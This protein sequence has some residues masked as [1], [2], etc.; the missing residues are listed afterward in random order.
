MLQCVHDGAQ[1]FLALSHVGPNVVPVAEAWFTLMVS[2]GD[3]TCAG[4]L[5]M[6]AISMNQAS[7]SA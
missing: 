3:S 7:G 2:V 4:F 1:R 6:L 5:A